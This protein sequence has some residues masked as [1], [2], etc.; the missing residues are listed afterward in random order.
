MERNLMILL[1]KK[2]ILLD[3]IKDKDTEINQV[4]VSLSFFAKF[5]QNYYLTQLQYSTQYDRMTLEKFTQ[6]PQT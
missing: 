1:L 3:G 5:L 4:F 2:K 6:K